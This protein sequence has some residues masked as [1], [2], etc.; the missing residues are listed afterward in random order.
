[1]GNKVLHINPLWS[2]CE[3]AAVFFIFIVCQE[4]KS[5]HKNRSAPGCCVAKMVVSV[6]A[7]L[8]WSKM[9]VGGS[10]RSH[11]KRAELLL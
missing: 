1:M 11:F 3:A 8:R 6:F 5:E 4:Y 10:Q 2:R 9:R 7:S